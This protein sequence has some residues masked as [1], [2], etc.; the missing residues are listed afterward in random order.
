M[1][2]RVSEQ[3]WTKVDPAQALETVDDGLAQAQQAQAA[4]PVDVGGSRFHSLD[5][6]VEDLDLESIVTQLKHQIQTNQGPASRRRAEFTHTHK[7][8][9]KASSSIPPQPSSSSEVSAQ[10]PQRRPG[11]IIIKEKMKPNAPNLVALNLKLIASSHA[12]KHK[13]DIDPSSTTVQHTS[14][15]NCSS[16]LGKS[17]SMEVEQPPSRGT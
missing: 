12:G 14:E 13:R 15:G 8:G 17:I 3:G 4:E 10:Q 16:R 1:Q 6:L 9:G 11:G 5:G 7:A 2:T